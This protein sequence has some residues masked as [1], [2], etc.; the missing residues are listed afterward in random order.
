MGKHLWVSLAI[1]AIVST[2][3]SLAKA[4][5]PLRNWPC[6]G[7]WLQPAKQQTDAGSRLPLLVILHGDEG[8][9][10]KLLAAWRRVASK[11]GVVLFAPRSPKDGQGGRSWWRWNGDPGWL[12]G[13]VQALQS[14]HRTDPERRYL[15]GWSGGATYISMNAAAWSGR[16]AAVSLAGGGAPANDGRCP[17]CP[18]PVHHLM[19][20]NNPLRSLAESAANHFRSCGHQLTWELLANRT[21]RATFRHYTMPAR[22][23]SIL[24]WL[25]EHS[26][27]QCP[28]PAPSA[29]TPSSQPS[30]RATGANA[31]PS[32]DTA[33]RSAS[34]QA[35]TGRATHAPTPSCTCNLPPTPGSRPTPAAFAILLASALCRRRHASLRHSDSR[36][37][38]SVS[39]RTRSPV[40]G[41]GQ[42]TRVNKLVSPSPSKSPSAATS[43]PLGPGSGPPR[44]G[45]K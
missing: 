26:G 1:M 45:P 7:C 40:T 43:K 31:Q 16:F 32:P 25:M 23:A 30:T 15:A 14:R 34:R 42:P 39:E 9:P 33:P 18:Y 20:G 13:H 24:S 3:P 35:P 11:A 17:S 21:H 27:D 38:K 36:S 28:A 29:A 4:Q 8:H 12:W 2:A 19:G 41:S 22:L 5:T 37:M 10:N 44:A 6:E